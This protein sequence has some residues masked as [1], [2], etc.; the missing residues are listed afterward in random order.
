MDEEAARIEHLKLVQ[1]V[2]SRLAGNSFALRVGVSPAIGAVV[3][4][5]VVI[6]QEFLVLVA[7][8]V[9]IT[10]W[11]LDAFYLAQERAFR[12]LYDFVRKGNG[13]AFGSESYFSMVHVTPRGFSRQILKT[14]ST[15]TLCVFYI[16]LISVIV[17][18]FLFLWFE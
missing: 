17:A 12:A 9:V 18:V 11:Y 4:A 6:S 7:L 1:I 15:T 2:I 14:M 5:A 10:F 3:T 16:P 8:L 13:Q